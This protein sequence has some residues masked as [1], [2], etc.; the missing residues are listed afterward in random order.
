MN[1][2]WRPPDVAESDLAYFRRNINATTRTRFAFEGEF[3]ADDLDQDGLACFVRA[4]VERDSDGRPTR[5]AR[6]LLFCEG[7]TA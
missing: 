2:P 4:I 7:G 5:R 3:S 6:W 1:A